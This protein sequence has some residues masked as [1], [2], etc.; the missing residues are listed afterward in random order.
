LTEP[1]INNPE[2]EP[3]MTNEE[4]LIKV[5]V[6]ALGTEVTPQD[7]IP[8]EVACSEVMTTLVQKVFS[9]FPILPSTRD[10]FNKLKSDKRFKATLTPRQGVI[11]VSPRTPTTIGHVGTFVTDSMIASN[12]S[13]GVNKG[14]FT[15]NYSWNGWINEFRNNRNLKIYLFE[16]L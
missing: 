8:D 16:V 13:F 2:T 11:I 5:C 12:N 7:R 3:T 15:G 9:D 4:K 10:L 6:D 14:K 1:I